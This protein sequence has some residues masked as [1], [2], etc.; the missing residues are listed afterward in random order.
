MLGTAALLDRA[1]IECQLV[2]ISALKRGEPGW[3]PPALFCALML[4]TWHEFSDV[5]LAEV[6]DDR[7]SFRHF[8]GFAAHERTPERI[9]F[10]RLAGCWSSGAG[11]G[12]WSRR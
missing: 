3:R 1:E 7:A 8:C 12:H 2:G 5:R 4:A 11:P 10:V 6:L 9:A